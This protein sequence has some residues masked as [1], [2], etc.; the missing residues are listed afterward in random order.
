MSYTYVKIGGSFITFKERPVTL[1][2]RAL[3]SLGEV[4]D[5]V[6]GKTKLIVGNG[7]GSFAHYTVLKYRDCG[8]LN[9]LVKCHESTR[10]LNRIVVNYLV[11]RGIP[12]TSVQTS[13][14]VHYND[15]EERFEVFYKPIETLVDVG[16]IPVV[17]GECIPT[18]RGV[19]VLSTERVFE[20]MSEFLRPKRV[21]LLT[22]VAG[23]Y[24]C[25]PKKCSNPELIKKITPSNVN[26]ILGILR[27]QS[28]VDATGGV[29]G[30]I[31]TMSKLASRFKTEVIIVSG[32][33]VDAVVEAIMGGTPEKSTLI[34]YE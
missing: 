10:A 25:D 24:T 6:Y 18:K 12:A 29:Y 23:I 7:G 16:A 33:D 17:Y 13:A 8:S 27:G 14:I 15:S 3:D 20:L 1:N 19:L 11:T 21:V 31:L 32:F 2:Y 5:R 26:Y 4:L 9:L 28:E 34:T 30:K 22:D